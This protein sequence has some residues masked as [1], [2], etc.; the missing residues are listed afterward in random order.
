MTSMK[1][2]S[3]RSVVGLGSIAREF[4]I[5]ETPR[6]LAG[7]RQ[8]QRP[9][10]KFIGFRRPTIAL[11][12][13]HARALLVAL[14]CFFVPAT[15]AA[16]VAD[17]TFDPPEGPS[18]LAVVFTNLSSGVI[19]S[20]EWDFGDGCVIQGPAMTS[21]SP[22][23]SWDPIHSYST[24]GTFSVTLTVSNSG[25]SDSEICSGCITVTAP[26][27]VPGPWIPAIPALLTHPGPQPDD[28]FSSNPGLSASG[29]VLAVGTPYDDVPGFVDAGS[30]AIFQRDSQDQWLP[31]NTTAGAG[32]LQN[33]DLTQ[34]FGAFGSGVSVSGTRLV[35][36]ASGWTGTSGPPEGRIYLYERDPANPQGLWLAAST[37]SGAGEIPN[38]DPSVYSVFGDSVSLSGDW[39][40]VVSPE[41]NTFTGAVHLY[42]R[43]SNNVWQQD[44]VIQLPTPFSQGGVSVSGDF[45]AVVGRV[46]S[47]ADHL[48]FL[49]EFDSNSQAWLPALTSSSLP[50]GAFSFPRTALSEAVRLSLSG[51]FLAVAD[52]CGALIQCGTA[53]QYN[54]GRVH[55]FER[56]TLNGWSPAETPV[57]THPD[58]QSSDCFGVGVSLSGSLLAVG[59]PGD[60]LPGFDR[61]GS[62]HLFER[63]SLTGRWLLAAPMITHSDPYPGGINFGDMDRF[64]ASVALSGEF[65]AVGAVTDN[66]PTVPGDNHGSVHLFRRATQFMRPDCNVDGVYDIADAIKVLN[67]LFMG[68]GGV[69][70]CLA[71][72]DANADAAIDVADAISILNGLFV[73]G[74]P[75]IAEPFGACGFEPFTPT[76]GCV[77]YGSCP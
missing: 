1:H 61:A 36:A 13:R 52:I 63:D 43:D 49:Y 53:P 9:S 45:M 14:F 26:A 19:D 33:P 10:K 12:T 18:P 67:Y 64:G 50:S 29:D 47:T 30:V 59:T 34:D 74:S 77:S 54:H 2:S 57:L 65:L 27:Q 55:L 28:G 56:D 24:A 16:Q 20:W 40:A 51:D 58:P 35:V 62:V 3:R 75:P 6:S 15:S 23:D 66:L 48:V 4:D 5:E 31:A 17:F 25:G 22:D 21:M 68:S 71:A 39:L 42:H 41:F 32:L 73:A 11:H 69:Y 44:S 72:C 76:A 70:S 46:T 60:D 8:N 7:D 37:F 38:P